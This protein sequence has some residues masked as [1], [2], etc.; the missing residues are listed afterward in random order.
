MGGTLSCGGQGH[1]PVAD[2]NLPYGAPVSKPI[3][4]VQPQEIQTKTE[5][6]TGKYMFRILKIVY[7]WST[8]TYSLF[9]IIEPPLC[10][11]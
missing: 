1:R 9:T 3:G 8:T 11:R 6:F 7:K 10:I 4:I 2:D 5:D